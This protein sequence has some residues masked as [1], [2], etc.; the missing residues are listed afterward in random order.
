MCFWSFL[1]IIGGTGPRVSAQWLF[2]LTAE[3]EGQICPNFNT[4]LNIFRFFLYFYKEEALKNE[5]RNHFHDFYVLILGYLTISWEKF[6]S[7]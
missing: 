4:I 5:V 7:L 1:G 3:G 2:L 6:I